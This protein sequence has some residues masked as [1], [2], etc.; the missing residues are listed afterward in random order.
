MAPCLICCFIAILFYIENFRN[1]TT[2]IPWKL[3]LSG[4]SERFNAIYRNAEVEFPKIS[5]KM[6]NCK[7]FYEAQTVS[8]LK[9]IIQ[10]PPN[11]PSTI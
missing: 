7:T 8:R 5:I 11:P 1:L 10:P 2:V 3:I 4:N 6:K 9:E